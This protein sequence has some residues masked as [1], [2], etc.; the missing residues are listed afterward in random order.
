MTA[1]TEPNYSLQEIP[2]GAWALGTRRSIGSAKTLAV[3]GDGPVAFTKP[4][5]PLATK[6]VF[7]LALAPGGLLTVLGRI[8]RLAFE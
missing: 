1:V 6:P 8:R 2:G 7:P 5:F 3:R 4:V